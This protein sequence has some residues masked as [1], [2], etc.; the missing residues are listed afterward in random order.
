MA[1]GWARICRTEKGYQVMRPMRSYTARHNKIYPFKNHSLMVFAVL[2]GITISGCSQM[3]MQVG[4]HDLTT[5]TI[6]TGSI[7]SAADEAYT[8]LSAE[9]R[10]TIAANLDTLDNDL[11]DGSDL[12]GLTLP[13]LNRMSGNSGTVSDISQTAFTQTGCVTFKTTANTIA[14]IKLYSGTACRDISE[15]FAVTALVVADA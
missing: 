5:P 6:L 7:P 10:Q 8:D 15:K 14:G 11:R 1:G 12:V 13:W 9:D 4:T 2:A 3:G